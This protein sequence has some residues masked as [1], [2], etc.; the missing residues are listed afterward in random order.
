M[1]QD[2]LGKVEW[3]EEGGKKGKPKTEDKE[4]KKEKKK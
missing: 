1:R 2:G 4:D 3:I